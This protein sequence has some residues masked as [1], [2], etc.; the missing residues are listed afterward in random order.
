MYEIKRQQFLEGVECCHS[1]ELD[2]GALLVRAKD[3]QDMCSKEE[4]NALC[5]YLTLPNLRDHPDFKQWSVEQGRYECFEKILALFKPVSTI[6]VSRSTPSSRAM[7]PFPSPDCWPCCV[8]PS[9]SKVGPKRPCPF[10]QSRR[11]LDCYKQPETAD[12]VGQPV[13]RRAWKARQEALR[14][15]EYCD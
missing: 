12:R 7:R 1:D 5:S 15:L 6:S 9:S 14:Q 4:F 11:A 8:R 10:P 13:R 2:T 3:L